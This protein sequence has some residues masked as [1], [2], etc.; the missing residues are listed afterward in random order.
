M[1]AMETVLV[2]CVKHGVPMV[3][4]GQGLIVVHKGIQLDVEPS[5]NIV[6]LSPY[7]GLGQRLRRK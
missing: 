5:G 6:H 1:V 7:L 3:V 2:T 4:H